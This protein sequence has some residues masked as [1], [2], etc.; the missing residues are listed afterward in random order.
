MAAIIPNKAKAVTKSDT[1]NLPESGSL[2][3]GGAGN[4]KGILVGDSDP[5]TFVGIAAGTFMPVEFKKIFDTD[6]T[7]TSMLVLFS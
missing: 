4:I 5:V 2:Y 6:T 7:A 3:V 1:K